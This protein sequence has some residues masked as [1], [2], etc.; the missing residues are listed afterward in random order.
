ML[1][2]SQC[3]MHLEDRLQEMYLKS[4]MLSEYLRGHTRVHVKELGV[5]LGWVRWSVTLSSLCDGVVP[6]TV[7]T[8]PFSLCHLTPA[9]PRAHWRV[10]GPS[11]M[12]LCCSPINSMFLVS[13]SGNKCGTLK[14]VVLYVNLLSGLFYVWTWKITLHSVCPSVVISVR[15][16]SHKLSDAAMLGGR[17][18]PA[19]S[20]GLAVPSSLGW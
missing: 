15:C 8:D 2:A 4:K 6:S 14:L 10:W 18:L 12:C 9:G 11:G 13:D 7:P 1:L 19:C 17:G 20:R 5:V 16:P 3:I